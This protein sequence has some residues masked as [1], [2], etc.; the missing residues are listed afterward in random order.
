M[1]QPRT[2][3]K[4]LMKKTR[5]KNYRPQNSKKLLQENQYHSLLF[6][7][8]K[9]MQFH[10]PKQPSQHGKSGRTTTRFFRVVVLADKLLCKKRK[11]IIRT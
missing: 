8:Y 4:S 6:F 2:K 7:S 11:R 3:Y 1:Q 10:V 5:Q 9:K